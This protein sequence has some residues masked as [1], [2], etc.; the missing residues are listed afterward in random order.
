MTTWSISSV[1]TVDA[2][3]VATHPAS[4]GEAEGIEVVGMPVGITLGTPL[5]ADVRKVT[6]NTKS[7]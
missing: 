1:V 7:K 5:G 4:E 2:L 6:Q 3:T